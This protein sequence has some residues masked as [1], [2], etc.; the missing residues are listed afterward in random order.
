[1]KISKE[2]RE[3]WEQLTKNDAFNQWL[4]PQVTAPD[5]TLDLDR[6]HAIALEYGID[7]REQYAHLNPGQQR[8]NLGNMLRKAVPRDVYNGDT[9]ATSAPAITT[10][11][12]TEPRSEALGRATVR[13]LLR[14]HAEVLD[15]L[16]R[17]EVVRTSNSP[18]G[19]Y[20]EL[21]FATAFGW[22]LENSSAAGH[23]AT[24]KDGVRYQIK[25]RRLTKHNGSRQL[26][27]LRRLPEKK[28][29]YLAAVLFDSAYQVQQAI[30][31]PHE[32]LE[33]RCRY[34]KHANG[35][36]FRLE[37]SCWEMPGARDVTEQICAAA[38]AI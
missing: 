17:R 11:A 1:M 36:L 22:E 24:D 13:E 16:R 5:G 32:G 19:D 15:E 20:A 7:K 8:M 23:D 4:A 37:D 3:R 10:A 35:W 27:F 38:N 18:V 26:S 6:L 2:R 28:F 12:P 34:S 9:P 33:A 31:L 14:L 29:D 25:S 30:I 21:L